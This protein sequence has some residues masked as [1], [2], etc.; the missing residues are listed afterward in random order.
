MA[1]FII[2]LA[3]MLDVKCKELL[4]NLSSIVIGVT[5]F[6]RRSR[7]TDRSNENLKK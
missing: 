3:I 4:T 6:S 5:K 7:S 1:T 2:G